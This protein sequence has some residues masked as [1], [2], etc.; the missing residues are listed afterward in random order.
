M[1]AGTGKGRD[2]ICHSF[3]Q[4]LR[5]GPTPTI[6]PTPQT[7]QTLT[8]NPQHFQTSLFASTTI[9][10]SRPGMQKTLPC[11]CPGLGLGRP[12]SKNK[13]LAFDVLE[14]KFLSNFRIF[15][16]WAHRQMCIRMDGRMNGQT[17]RQ[18][19]R[20]IAKTRARMSMR[21]KRCFADNHSTIF[22]TFDQAI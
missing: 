10:F 5:A 3:S 19:D 18:T 8:K 20:H 12:T 7:Y 11:S 22:H 1:R 14:M 2:C 6:P 16:S 17:D 21:K 15:H 4:L 9:Y 13:L